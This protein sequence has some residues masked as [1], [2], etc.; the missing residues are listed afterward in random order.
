MVQAGT[1]QR[2]PGSVLTE[3]PDGAVVIEPLGVADRLRQ[4]RR[5]RRQAST[6]KGNRE[7]P[8]GLAKLVNRGPDSGQV[9]AGR[10]LQLIDENQRA[11]AK[12]A[13][14]FAEDLEQ[15]GQVVGVTAG[16]RHTGDW[17]HVDTD[18]D[19]SAAWVEL[20]REPL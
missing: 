7:R 1:N 10:H 19:Q 2:G 16:V 12:V 3:Q 20:E 14:G 8:V 11:D 6:D 5:Q 4:L 17:L 13:G 9:V 18:G 15:C